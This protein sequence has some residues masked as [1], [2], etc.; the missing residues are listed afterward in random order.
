VL[1]RRYWR[2]LDLPHVPSERAAGARQARVPSTVSF[3]RISI[4]DLNKSSAQ[5]EVHILQPASRA[6]HS[7]LKS[8][9]NPFHIFMAVQVHNYNSLF[10]LV[11]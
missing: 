1:V 8:S 6:V 11:V 4:Y 3:S 7:F 2:R 9:P 10:C 5:P